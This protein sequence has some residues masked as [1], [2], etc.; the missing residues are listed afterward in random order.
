MG[1]ECAEFVA[2]SEAGRALNV[3]CEGMIPRLYVQVNFEIN[4]CYSYTPSVPRPILGGKCR[5]KLG[6]K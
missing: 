6:D 4:D 5:I 3:F 1:F 2:L